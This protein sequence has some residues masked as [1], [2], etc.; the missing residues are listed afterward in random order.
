[1]SRTLRRWP[2][3]LGFCGAGLAIGLGVTAIQQ[4]IYEAK[5]NI[6]FPTQSRTPTLGSFGLDS[7]VGSENMGLVEGIV[8]SREVEN[9]LHDLLK[10]DREEIRENMV[11]AQ[12]PARRQVTIAY[13]SG[14]KDQAIE[15]VQLMLA[16]LQQVEE[17]LGVNTSKKRIEALTTALDERIATVES[18]EKRIL[19]FQ[20]SSRTVPDPKDGFTGV[21]Y[22]KNRADLQEDL[23]ANRRR[24]E[25]RRQAA[26]RV[27]KA[28]TEGLPTGLE[29]ESKLR[30][31]LVAAA[32][33]LDQARA[34]YQPGSAQLRDAEERYSA[35]KRNIAGEVQKYVSSV[36]Q[37]ADAEMAELLGEQAVLKWEFERAD[38]LARL[39]PR[40]AAEY[41]RL[42]EQLVLEKKSRDELKA[43][44]GQEEIRV[45]V[46]AKIWQVLD[47]PFVEDEPVNKKFGMNGGLGLILGGLIGS[48]VANRSGK[49]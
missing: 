21:T 12:I 47:E 16:N 37:G 8:T 9:E 28:A 3:V 25:S 26:N 36:Q 22:L 45:K 34:K 19:E 18:L 40:E 5:A 10:V 33:A 29:R 17:G 20:R 43:Q 48:V 46:E 49:K 30:E 31:D 35:T 11:V 14:E 39:A 32:V 1:M 15:A 13:R 7:V 38:Q 4:P 24:V 44:V 27:G 23:E 41:G 42:I 2:T 6:V